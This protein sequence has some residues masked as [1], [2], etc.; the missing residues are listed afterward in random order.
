VTFTRP[1]SQ[2]PMRPASLSDPRC[3]GCDRPLVGLVEISAGTCGVCLKRPDAPPPP[4]HVIR[5][6]SHGNVEYSGP[7]RPDELE[8]LDA[9]EEEAGDDDG[10]D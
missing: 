3:S 9:N 1:A 2:F 7:Q 5:R 8:P 10:S 6:D 4:K